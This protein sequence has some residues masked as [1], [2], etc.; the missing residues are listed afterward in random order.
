MSRLDRVL[1]YLSNTPDL[2]INI[3]VKDMKIFGYVDASWACHNDLK[4]HS[5]IIITLGCNGF[6]LYCKSIKQ[7]VVSRSSTEAELIALF[8]GMDYLLY[9][10]RLVIFL[11]YTPKEPI[12]IMQDNTSAITMAYMGKTSSGSKCKFME[13][14]YFWIKDYLDSKIFE[15]KYLNTDEM[16]ADLMASPR[17][18]NAFRSMRKLI[19]G[20]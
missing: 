8:T 18:G 9:F 15:L 1:G 13:L 20:E 6:P 3:N 12:I 16:I 2:G 11:G 14:K 4:G 7:K 5:G 17:I 10:R 19:L